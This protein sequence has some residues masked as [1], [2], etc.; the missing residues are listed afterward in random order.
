M[1]ARPNSGTPAPAGIN[2]LI[3]PG[4]PANI[5]PGGQ[6]RVTEVTND[7]Y[8][9]AERLKELNPR[10][11][12][13]L[14]QDSGNGATAFTIVEETPTGTQVVFRCNQL[15]QRVVE[16][17]AYLLKVPFAQR[18]AEAEKAQEKFEAEEH[19]SELDSLVERIGL[20]MVRD[21]LECGF[22]D[23]AFGD[24]RPKRFGAGA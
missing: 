7:V 14:T 20:P 15:D 11:A 6:I 22:I 8:H 9:I 17:V 1:P 5:R 2:E 18:F 24:R 4:V 19:E 3:L 16:Y 21:L 10:L 12:V 13:N 23:T